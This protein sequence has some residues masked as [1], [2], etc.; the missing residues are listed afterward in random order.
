VVESLSL[1]LFQTTAH[2]RVPSVGNLGA[3]NV[4]TAMT[5]VKGPIYA[6]YQLARIQGAFPVSSLV[7]G[8]SLG[9]GWIA[10]GC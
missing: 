7:L 10:I 4:N 6:E 2:S 9:G 5:Q 3:A 8:A 1:S